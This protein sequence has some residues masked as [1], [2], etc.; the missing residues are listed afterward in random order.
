[1]PIEVLP[2]SLTA[3]FTNAG[4]RKKLD[5]GRPEGRPRSGKRS[6]GDTTTRVP[7]DSRTTVQTV[8]QEVLTAGFGMGPGRHLR[9]GRVQLLLN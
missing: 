1:M 5:L 7:V 2:T 8:T 6:E 4:V 9:Y 3:V